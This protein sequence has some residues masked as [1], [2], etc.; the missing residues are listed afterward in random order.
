MLLSIRNTYKCYANITNN[1]SVNRHCLSYFEDKC[2]PWECEVN[3]SHLAKKMKS[4][5]PVVTPLEIVECCWYFLKVNL[6]YFKNKWD[7]SSFIKKYIPCDNKNVLWQVF[8][9]AIKMNNN[10]LSFWNCV[11]ILKQNICTM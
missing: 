6:N 2:P 7:W 5:T 4:S 10:V 3:H 11:L 1:S 9:H 8:N